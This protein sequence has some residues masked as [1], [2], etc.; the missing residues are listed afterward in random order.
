MLYAPVVIP[1]L[2][3]D[4]HLKKC[5][6]SLAANSVAGNTDIYIS[7]DYP[8]SEKYAVGYEKVKDLLKTYDF[9]RFKSHHVLYQDKNLGPTGNSD[10]LVNMVGAIS[11]YIIYTEDDNEFSPNY[12]YYMDKGF[13][14][15]RNDSSVVYMCGSSDTGWKFGA[16]ANVMKS[17]LLS[18]YGVGFWFSRKVRFNEEGNNYLLDKKNWTYRNFRSLY[19]KNRVLFWIY[20]TGILG[21]EDGLNI[22]DRNQI[23]FCD[24]STSIYMHYS[25]YVCVCPRLAK[26]RTFGNDGSGVNMPVM[27]NNSK[28]VLDTADTFDYVYPE[29]F[30]F[31][32]ENYRKGDDIMYHEMSQV[33]N[34]RFRLF[35]AWL[36]ALY[37]CITRSRSLPILLRRCV[38]NIRSRFK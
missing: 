14:E 5:L 28:D 8:P 33:V 17:K 27:E 31:D 2:N 6:D 20:I 19:K 37:I 7:V 29:D 22:K 13:E 36:I 10:L 23:I 34:L 15:F 16:D 38:R 21:S 4:W 11:D 9:S 18:A 26:S 3:R 1:T 24:S 30:C 25:D 32:D 35:V 12:L